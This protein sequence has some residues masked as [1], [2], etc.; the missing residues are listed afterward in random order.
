MCYQCG[1]AFETDGFGVKLLLE[2][3]F[4]HKFDSLRFCLMLPFS[5]VGFEIQCGSSLL[6]GK[7]VINNFCVTS[8]LLRE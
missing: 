8:G 1:V 2:N 3:F 6:H 5:S 7:L 4:T